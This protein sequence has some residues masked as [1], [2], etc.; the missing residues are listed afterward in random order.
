[1]DYRTY[2]YLQTA[3]DAKARAMVDALPEVAGRFDP[4]GV[5]SA[6]PN[7]AAIFAMA[8]IPARYALERGAWAEAEALAPRPSSYPYTEA[9]TYLA[10]ALG[11][12]HRDNADAIKASID[13]L[14]RITDTLT[15]QNETYWAGQTEIQLRE[16]VAWLALTEGR[17]ADALAAMRTAVDMEDR[18]EKAAV[19]PGPLAP[20]RELLGEMLLQLNQPA[21]ALKEFEA[22]MKKEPN[23]FRAVY[24]AAHA[25]ALA[26]NRAKSRTYYAQLLKICERGDT[27]GRPELVEA[28]RAR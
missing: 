6:A 2:A 21:D 17:G 25:A 8:A 11:A 14:H 18:T 27:P 28:R 12:A 10:R 19:T 24:G 15:G 22:T 7:S 1:M 26:G 9:L 3:Q 13:A 4:N 16:A 23:R 20:A 5:P